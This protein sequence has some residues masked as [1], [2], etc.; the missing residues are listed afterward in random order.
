MTAAGI[1]MM[2]IRISIEK[3]MKKS[4][5]IL[6][7]ET[8]AGD[9]LEVDAGVRVVVPSSVRCLAGV[10]QE[11]LSLPRTNTAGSVWFEMFE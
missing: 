2:R 4:V 5:L 6:G 11:R 1:P 3:T 7:T 9:C 8:N 10:Q